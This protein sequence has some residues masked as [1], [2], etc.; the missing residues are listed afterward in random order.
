MSVKVL[1]QTSAHATGGRDGHSATLDVKL[2][3]P[4][5]LGGVGTQTNLEFERN[6]RG[7]VAGVSEC[8]LGGHVCQG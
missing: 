8:S 2:S 4:K 7:R 3:T 6:A 5:E 1:Y